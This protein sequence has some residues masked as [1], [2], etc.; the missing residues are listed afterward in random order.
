[1][2]G[3]EHSQSALV[4]REKLD[5]FAGVGGNWENRRKERLFSWRRYVPR[6]LAAPLRRSIYHQRLSNYVQKINSDSHSQI[7]ALSHIKARLAVVRGQWFIILRARPRPPG[8]TGVRVPASSSFSV[9]SRSRQTI[10][11][12]LVSSDIFYKCY[13]P[14]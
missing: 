3:R 13:I 6:N 4:F 8:P 5:T 11:G 1:M 12:S 14:G 10:D 7:T 2:L 9:R